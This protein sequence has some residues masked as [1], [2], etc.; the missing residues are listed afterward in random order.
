MGERTEIMNVP[1]CQHHWE[2][3]NIEFGY[4]AFERCFHCNGLRTHFSVDNISLLGDEYR[5]GNHFWDRVET[6][7]SFRFDLCCTKCRQVEI[8]DELMGF[9]HCTECLPSCQVDVLQKKYEAEK[10]W[11]MVAF[12]FLPKD[13][14]APLGSDKLD[15]LTDY[16]NQRRDTSRSRIKI[17]SFDLIEDFSVC[18]GDFIHDVGMLSP[19]PPGPRKPLL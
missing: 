18:R 7:Q 5:E 2:M 11:I 9:L 1:D 13:E 14:S 10:T 19:E 16:F 12:G 6:A 3:I 8:Y 17:V 15:I 4:V